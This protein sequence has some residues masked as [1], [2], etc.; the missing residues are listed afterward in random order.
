MKNQAY[1]FSCWDEN[2]NSIYPEKFS[3]ER[4]ESIRKEIGSSD[5][6]NLYENSPIS[7]EDA[8]FKKED[9]RYYENIA[10]DVAVEI[11]M[12]LDLGGKQE[13]TS[14][15][16][17]MCVVAVDRSMNWYVLHAKAYYEDLLEIINEIFRLYLIWKPRK[18]GVE[19]EKYSI[20]MKPFLDREMKRRNI[21]LPFEELKM[22]INDRISKKDRI[23]SMQPMI[24]RGQLYL[25]KEQTILE[26]QI[27]KFP[28]GSVDII[29]A[30]SR[31]NQIAFPPRNHTR[32][33]KRRIDLDPV[34]LRT[35]HNRN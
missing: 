31:I 30:L 15:P 16:T 13:G 24:E 1:I 21:I 2:H 18:I 14:T 9:L 4:L 17:G 33:H 23:L 27:L 7:S 28:R 22:K 35:H 3:N 29:D 25:K 5:F 26:D 34:Y 19:K 8:P 20:A 32:S 11:F 6:S 12:T 10:K